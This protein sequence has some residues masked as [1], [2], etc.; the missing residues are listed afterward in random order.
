MLFVGT[1]FRPERAGVLWRAWLGLALCASA[2][3]C[4][5][6]LAQ[7]RRPVLIAGEGDCPS[8]A[9]VAQI[10]KAMLPL[11]EVA[12]GSAPGGDAVIVSVWDRE[13]RYGVRVDGTTR[14]LSDERRRCEDRARAI[15]LI[16]A[17]A[18][19]PPSVALPE[20][21]PP[22]PP[23]P[24]APPPPSPPGSWRFALEIGA[25]FDAAP[26]VENQ[27]DVFS[28]GASLRAAFGG[29]HVQGV[30]AVAALT[31]T[32][33]D[34]GSARA[35]LLR[36]PLDIGVRLAGDW[37]RFEL[38]GELG[39]AATVLSVSGQDLAPSRDATRLE[40]GVRA[41]GMIAYRLGERWGPFL[42]VQAIFAPSPISLEASPQGALGTTPRLHVAG[43]LGATVR[44]H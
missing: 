44:L 2:S 19:E 38:S 9:H 7:A 34:L 40:L 14:D 1:S 35:R 39:I 28:F 8:P 36:F 30:A 17:L 24:T 25:L 6:A 4:P 21:R 15:A 5:A 31:P 12:V 18:V 32:T 41:A 16:V 43:V 42:A 13:Q 10:L 26:G 33:L 3:A 37:G 27:S 29:R 11:R 22:P 20:A 23:P